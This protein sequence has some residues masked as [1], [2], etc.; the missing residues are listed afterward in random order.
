MKTDNEG[1]WMEKLLSVWK[2]WDNFQHNEK[3]LVKGPSANPTP[4]H[5]SETGAT[6]SI[7]W[8]AK[9]GWKLVPPSYEP[10]RD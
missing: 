2:D 4:T 1:V 8:L 5:S 9:S 10:P 3:Y 7:K 6:G